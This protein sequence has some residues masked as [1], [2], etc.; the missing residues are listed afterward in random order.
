MHTDFQPRD[1][2]F[3]HTVRE[4]FARQGLMVHLGAELVAITPGCAEIILAFSP[5]ISQQHGYFHG[6]VIGMIAD[7]AGGYAGLSLM[8]AGSNVLTVE[9][10]LN[11]LMPAEG[12][13]LTARGH[14]VRSGRT[15]TITQIEVSVCHQGK[16]K[17]CALMQQTL[18]CLAAG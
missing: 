3:I 10:K 4:N 16:E 15:L 13:L 8:A 11:F 5:H 18:M 14:V 6:G 7:S 1:P 17:C 2:N 9:Y 12:N